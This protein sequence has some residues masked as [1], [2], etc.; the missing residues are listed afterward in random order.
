MRI[1][2]CR[3]RSG[4]LFAASDELAEVLD[5][6]H[7]ARLASRNGAWSVRVTGEPGQDRAARCGEWA[8]I[9]DREGGYAVWRH[10]GGLWVLHLAGECP[11]EEVLCFALGLPVRR[12]WTAEEILAREREPVAVL[13]GPA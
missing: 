1:Y 13:R 12:T 11:V 9:A 6:A 7:A 5:H 2:V 3:D 8:V 10:E 4:N